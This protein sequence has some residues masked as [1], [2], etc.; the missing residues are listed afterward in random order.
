MDK[1][2]LTRREARTIPPE[3]GIFLCPEEVNIPGFVQA[4][5]D[6]LD[7]IMHDS[8][9]ARL[10]LNTTMDLWQ[11]LAANK[12][13]RTYGQELEQYVNDRAN[14]AESRIQHVG[15]ADEVVA[16]EGLYEQANRYQDA[17]ATI[18]NTANN[19]S[20]ILGKNMLLGEVM[21]LGSNKYVIDEGPFAYKFF[22][23]VT[24]SDHPA[25][26]FDWGG[27]VDVEQYRHAG[28]PDQI[29]LI[30]DVIQES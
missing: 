16:V 11:Q 19:L 18:R 30:H 29:E 8:Q 17:C 3:G 20:H 27:E 24:Y 26:I 1:K 7:Q 22:M 4:N 13:R 5:I 21:L 28:L 25:I 14:D 9:Q 15:I 23:K 6:N 2:N 12:Q 10:E